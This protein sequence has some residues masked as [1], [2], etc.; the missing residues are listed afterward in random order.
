MMRIEEADST[1]NR[2][3]ENIESV[4]NR[5]NSFGGDNKEGIDPE[6]EPLD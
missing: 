4:V 1:L 2:H 6:D 5:E 3:F